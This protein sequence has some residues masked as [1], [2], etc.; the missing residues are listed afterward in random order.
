[1][2][3]IRLHYSEFGNGFPLV[4]LHGNGESSDYF[5]DQFNAFAE[6]YR[7]IAVDTRGHGSS[8]RGEAPFTLDAFAADLMDFFEELHIEKAHILGFS[9]GANIALLFA[10]KHPERVEK[11]ILNGADLFTGGVKPGVQAAVELSHGFFS[12]LSHFSKRAVRKKEMLGLMVGQPNI[13]P[14]ELSALHLP[15]LVIAGTRDMIRDSHTRLIAASIPGA[16]LRIIDGDHFIA[17]KNSE[18]F[19]REILSFLNN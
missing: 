16:R 4:L 17:A 18:P 7:V 10:M 13:K 8:P 2:N 1:M 9:D 14:D 3:D 12:L 5:K 6:Y 15:T 11:L 19:N